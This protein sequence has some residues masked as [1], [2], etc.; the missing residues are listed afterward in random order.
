MS[1]FGI[2]DIAPKLLTRDEVRRIA[3]DGTAAWT[4][5]QIDRVLVRIVF[6]EARPRMERATA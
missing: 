5:A 6:A 4:S 1:Q 2:A 3:V